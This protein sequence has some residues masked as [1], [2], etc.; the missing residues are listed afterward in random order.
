MKTFQSTICIYTHPY[1]G[2]F[3]EYH[4]K[5][6]A[7]SEEEAN[8]KAI[9]SL[10]FFDLGLGISS[11]S[12]QLKLDERTPT[13]RKIDWLE[14]RLNFKQ[15]DRPKFHVI[16]KWRQQLFKLRLKSLGSIAAKNL[17]WS[18][19]DTYLAK[20]WDMSRQRIGYHRKNLGIPSPTPHGGQRINSGRKTQS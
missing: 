13:Q 15:H 17:D 6:N 5:L 2:S 8:K 9:N 16:Q 20:I 14:S 3:N 11:H 12:S 7:S 1:S 18:K 19:G 10:K 4:L